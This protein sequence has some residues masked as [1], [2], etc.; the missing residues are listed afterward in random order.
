[1]TEDKF[2]EFVTLLGILNGDRLRGEWDKREKKDLVDAFN[3]E[4]AERWEEMRVRAD[5]LAFRE[6]AVRTEA[7]RLFTTIPNA[8]KTFLPGVTI[9]DTK[10][11]GWSPEEAMAWALEHKVALKLDEAAYKKLVA[12]NMAPGTVTNDFTVAIATNL[13]PFIK[14]TE[15][16]GVT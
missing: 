1:M 3:A 11:Y 8:S 7:L 16:G 14:A 9:R 5:L 13:E 2:F 12:A 10:V 4:H 15:G 6:A